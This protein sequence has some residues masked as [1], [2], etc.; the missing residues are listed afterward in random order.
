MEKVLLVE[1]IHESGVK[2]LEEAGL[3]AVVSPSAE[4][5]ALVDLVQDDVFGIIV[6]TSLLEGTVLEAGRRLKIVGRHGIGYNNIDL[7]TADKLNIVV[8]N[9]PDANAYSVAEYTIAAIMMLSRKLLPAFTAL[10]EGKLSQ[11]GAS[12]PGLV[13]KF[14]LGGNELPHRRVGIVGLGKIG[15]QVAEMAS[16][17]LRMDVIAY[18]PYRKEAPEYVKLVTN[19]D[20]VYRNADFIT[21]HVPLTPETENMISTAALASMKPS[22]YL[23]NPARG[24]LIDDCALADA[25]RREVIAG[26]VLDVFRQEP[27]AITSPL[28]LAPNIVLTPHI[29]G[30]TDEAVERLAIGAARAVADYYLGKKPAHIVNPQVWERLSKLGRSEAHACSR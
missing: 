27:P 24:E 29:A 17:F 9:V 25:L 8:T 18:D 3:K 4:T 2:I 21:L 19:L 7:K 13:K 22:A 12:L 5:A 23:I 10:K 20:E 14:Q 26:A 15:M 28:F 1:S 11:P 16:A 30:S 6:R